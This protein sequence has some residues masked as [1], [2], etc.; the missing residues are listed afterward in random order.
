MNDFLPAEIIHEW[1]CS[2]IRISRICGAHVL[3]IGSGLHY[4]AHCQSTQI[5]AGCNNLFY[6]S[7][8]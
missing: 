3:R 5:P 6:L 2:L 1:L 4:L 7:V 8:R